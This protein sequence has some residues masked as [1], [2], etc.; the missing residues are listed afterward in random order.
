[1]NT[2]NSIS[3]ADLAHFCELHHIQRLSL[4]GSHLHGDARPDSDIDLLAEF[5]P[6]HL[7][8]LLAISAMEIE[9][10]EMMGGRNVDLRTPSDLSRHFREQ[11]L[12]EAAVQYAR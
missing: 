10:G 11:V 3:S 6:E 7:P 4:F 8:G 12:R 2:L 5:D 9:L 1:M